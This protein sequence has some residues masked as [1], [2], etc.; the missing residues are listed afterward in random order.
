MNVLCATVAIRRTPPSRLA[1]MLARSVPAAFA[2][3]LAVVPRL[4]SAESPKAAGCAVFPVDNIWN[5]PVD[6]LPVDA[7]SDAYIATIGAAI[8]ARSAVGLQYRGH[9]AL[10][11]GLG[12]AHGRR[13]PAALRGALARTSGIVKRSAVAEV[14]QW[15]QSGTRGVVVP[16]VTSTLPS[17]SGLAVWP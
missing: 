8:S 2:L 14:T 3:T 12:G 10:V 4:A 16:P 5:V 15:S 13:R 7:N 17:A 9:K 1:S 6:H 11:P